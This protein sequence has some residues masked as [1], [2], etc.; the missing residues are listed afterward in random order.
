MNI[1]ITGGSSGLGKALVEQLD[2]EN[3][4][5]I[6][7]T[8]H[9]HKEAATQ[10]VADCRGHAIHAIEADFGNADTGNSGDGIAALLAS[11]DKMDLD[12]LVN[13]AYV[14]KPQAG[15]FH[16]IKHDDFL[17]SF[18]DNIVPVIRITQKALETFRK[19]KAGKIINVLTSYL[20]NLPPAGFAIYAAN[21]AY[22]WQLSKTWNK[23]Y[24]AYN[25][26]SNCVAPE[27]MQTGFA[28]VD[29]RIVEQMAAGHPLK[30]LLTAD[31]A[32]RVI[33]SLVHLSNQ[34]NGVTI[35]IN[36]GQALL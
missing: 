35:P 5:T 4:H 1:L 28:D 7:F 11:M 26:S 3:E 22:L 17:D 25:I 8:Y 29:P 9:R 32:A 23:E 15:H 27:Y 30:Q 12:V 21:K 34:V 31:D 18:K 10:L 2:G 16:K 33:C 19:K 24:A 13:N 6:Y 20:L 14:G 36:A